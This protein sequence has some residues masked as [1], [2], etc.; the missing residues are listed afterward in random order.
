M[1]NLFGI[2][3]AVRETR[4]LQWSDPDMSHSCCGGLWSGVFHEYFVRDHPF[5]V[6]SERTISIHSEKSNI[7]IVDL[8]SVSVVLEVKAMQNVVTWESTRSQAYHYIR[9]LN[10]QAKPTI[11]IVTRGDR[12]ICWEQTGSEHGFICTY[13]CFIHPMTGCLMPGG[14][15]SSMVDSYLALDDY[16]RDIKA[17]SLQGDF[18]ECTLASYCGSQ[19]RLILVHVLYRMCFSF[20]IMGRVSERLVYW[21]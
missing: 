10:K 11:A 5:T 19:L 17:R 9:R 20:H 15:P 3:D 16:L 2:N 7:A 21:I 6:E 8:K 14:T 12:F 13:K 18:A 4:K 1:A